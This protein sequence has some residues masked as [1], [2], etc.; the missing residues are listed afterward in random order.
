MDR[1]LALFVIGGV[2]VAQM[3]V[4]G[5][6]S[7][8]SSNTQLALEVASEAENGSAKVPALP[9]APHGK[10]TVIGGEIQ[11]VDPVRDQLRLKAYGQ[12]PMT[13]LFDERTQVYLDGKKLSLLDLRADDVPDL[14]PAVASALAQRTGVALRAQRAPI[15]VVVE[16]DQL[17]A[18]PDQDGVPGGEQ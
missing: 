10:S 5:A 1:S 4:A 11:N 15:G 8:Q 13:I 7:E 2:L 6:K 9:A 3:L 14:D 17:A 16:L 12:K 18:P